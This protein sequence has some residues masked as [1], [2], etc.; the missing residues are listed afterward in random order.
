MNKRRVRSDLI[1]HVEKDRKIVW[2]AFYGRLTE[3]MFVISSHKSCSPSSSTIIK[4]NCKS[5]RRRALG[6]ISTRDNG[7][8]EAED[9]M[10]CPL[11]L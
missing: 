4:H 9:L 5:I 1:I 6:I 10:P 7:R 11:D 8:S 2:M 3:M